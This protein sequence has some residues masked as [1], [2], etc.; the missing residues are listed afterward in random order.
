[1]HGSQH[2]QESTVS[3]NFDRKR[4][5]YPSLVYNLLSRVKPKFRFRREGRCPGEQSAR[6]SSKQTQ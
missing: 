5:D 1:M 2:R 6:G 3:L 4:S